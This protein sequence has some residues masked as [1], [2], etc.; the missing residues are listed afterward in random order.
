VIRFVC[1]P[2][3]DFFSNACGCGCFAE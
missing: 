2:N 1:P 3:E